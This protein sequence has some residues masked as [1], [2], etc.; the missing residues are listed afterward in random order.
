MARVPGGL[1]DH[2]NQNPAKVHWAASERLDLGDC[3]E[4]V[5]QTQRCAA[6]VARLGVELNDLGR[7][8]RMRVSSPGLGRLRRERPKVEASSSLRSPLRAC[9]ASGAGWTGSAA[10]GRPVWPMLRAETSAQRLPGY[11]RNESI[12]A[13]AFFI[14]IVSTRA[15]HFDPA[16]SRGHPEP[17]EGQARLPGIVEPFA[18]GDDRAVCVEPWE[19]DPQ[20]GFADAFGARRYVVLAGHLPPAVK[21]AV[22]KAPNPK[23]DVTL[24]LDRQAV[25]HRPANQLIDAVH[26]EP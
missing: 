6:P 14:R 18:H 24:V 19:Y 23:F 25:L 1:I 2:V 10:P 21:P 8:R 4:R 5:A 3:V 17:W 7:R 20:E 13:S 9:A 16:G 15:P 26:V 12:G 11:S 22:E